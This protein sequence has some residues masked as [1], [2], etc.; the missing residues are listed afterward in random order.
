MLTSSQLYAAGYEAAVRGKR[1]DGSLWQWCS[2]RDGFRHGGED[3]AMLEL[4]PGRQR[5]RRRPTRQKPPTW[6]PH[7]AAAATRQTVLF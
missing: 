2:Y 7:V 5:R 4:R 3:D 6:Y 1:P